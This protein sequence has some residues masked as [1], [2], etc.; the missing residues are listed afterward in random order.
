VLS[1][2]FAASATLEDQR[3]P[4][5]FCGFPRTY[6]DRPVPYPV[7][8]KPQAWAAGSVLLLLQAVL[9]LTIDAWEHHVSFRQ[10]TLPAWLKRLEVSGLRVRDAT[11]DLRIHRARSG[12]AVE[13]VSREGDLTVVTA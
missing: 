5:L 10:P 6:Q 2:L 7:A 9:G 1:G 13:V 11:L 4:E 8:C 3:L 12:A